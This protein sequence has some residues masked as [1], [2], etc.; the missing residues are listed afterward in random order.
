[1][2]RIETKTN[3]VMFHRDK[4]VGVPRCKWEF[5]IWLLKIWGK[6]QL[7]IGLGKMVFT[8]LGRK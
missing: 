1:M 6:W 3:T 7:R 8:I 2:L 5:G 4:L